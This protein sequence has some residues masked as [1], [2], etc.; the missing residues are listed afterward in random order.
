MI[1]K[2]IA[3]TAVAVTPYVALAQGTA[4]TQDTTAMGHTQSHM[5]STHMKS[6]KMKP[7]VKVTDSTSMHASRHTGMM[8]DS[9]SM[10]VSP[11]DSA[12]MGTPNTK[13]SKTPPRSR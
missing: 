2:I 3:I 13:Q 5:D 4:Q 11:V 7:K 8:K 12:R 9:S 1:L 10:N 6:M